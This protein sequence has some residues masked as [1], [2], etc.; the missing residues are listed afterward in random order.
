[1]GLRRNS[2]ILKL[3]QGSDFQWHDG[4][5]KCRRKADGNLTGAESAVQPVTRSLKRETPLQG[6]GPAS[7]R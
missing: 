7:R 5:Q 4:R 3:T 6:T 2:A 1:M